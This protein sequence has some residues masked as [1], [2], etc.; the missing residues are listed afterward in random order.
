M[1]GPDRSALLDIFQVPYGKICAQTN[2]SFLRENRDG[3]SVA[4]TL[5]LLLHPCGIY[6]NVSTAKGDRNSEK[7][8]EKEEETNRPIEKDT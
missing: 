2:S 6:W 8:N 5:H 7:E 4:G 1:I 3:G